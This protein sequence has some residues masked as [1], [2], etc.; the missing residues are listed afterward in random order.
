MRIF[1]IFAF[2]LLNCSQSHDC[3]NGTRSTGFGE[4]FLRNYCYVGLD[5]VYEKPHTDFELGST[6]L[7]CTRYLEKKSLCDELKGPQL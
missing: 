6:L 7:F 4:N 1:V 2:F 3:K 5:A